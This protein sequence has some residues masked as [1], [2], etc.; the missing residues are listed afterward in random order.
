LRLYPAPRV[1]KMSKR[2]QTLIAACALSVSTAF[3]QPAADSDQ[4]LAS[5]FW[6][7]RA[8]T[9]QYT[10][11]DVM[12]MERPLGVVRDWSAAGVEKQRAPLTTFELR[13][14]R[15]ER[16]PRDPG[17]GEKNLYEVNELSGSK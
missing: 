2:W 17:P 6:E 16:H 4:K 9:G 14:R 12:R 10:S 15:Q 1:V 8:Q 5:D 3:S 7:W 13:W 11:D